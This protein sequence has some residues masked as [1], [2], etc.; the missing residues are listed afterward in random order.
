MHLYNYHSISAIRAAR[1]SRRDDQFVR[2]N[3]YAAIEEKHVINS[4]CSVHKLARSQ[5][6]QHLEM[7]LKD[8][9]TWFNPY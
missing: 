2:M 7:K 9:E 1:L 3:R 8:P 4:H 6:Y 5:I